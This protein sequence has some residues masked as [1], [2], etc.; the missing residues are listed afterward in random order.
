ME[1]WKDIPGYEGIYQA[2]TLG[3]IRTA[4]GKTT[5]N[6]RYPIRRWKSRILKAKSNSYKTGKRVSLWKDGKPRDW[7]IARL[8]AIT[9]LGNPQE[10][11]TVN[12]KDGDRMNN[13]VDN[14]EWLSSADNIRH[15]FS[16]GLY[17]TKKVELS[18]DGKTL[19]FSSMAKC[20]VFL[21]RCRGYTSGR[22]SKKLDTVI[23]ASGTEFIVLRSDERRQGHGERR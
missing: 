15:G 11:F 16:S 12:H 19:E 1:I 10:L 18:H 14:L 7:L 22:L 4:D 3:N 23:D 21:K 13:C 9:F 5:S 2:S 8:V 6:K 20:D 17:P